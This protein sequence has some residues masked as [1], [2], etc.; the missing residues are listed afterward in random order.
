M[1]KPGDAYQLAFAVAYG[2]DY[3]LSWNQ[4]HLAN[5]L[6]Q[7]RLRELAS[8]RNWRCPLLVTPDTIPRAALGQA[9]RRQD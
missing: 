3:L 4:A 2:M 9:L 7:V 6:T 1:G 5:A 8:E